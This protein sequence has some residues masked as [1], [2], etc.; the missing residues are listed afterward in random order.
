MPLSVPKGAPTCSLRVPLQVPMP[1]TASPQAV[2]P[3][4]AFLSLPAGPEWCL[5]PWS[6]DRPGADSLRLTS[7][8]LSACP[9]NCY[10]ALRGRDEEDRVSS[11]FRVSDS[12]QK[13]S[14]KGR[15]HWKG[16]AG[17]A[18]VLAAVNESA[19]RPRR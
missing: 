4:G 11:A 16:K 8:Y 10:L 19:R 13:G 17:L 2:A 5:G 6:S 7:P 18:T 15:F 9:G 3:G 12:G 14:K 1:E